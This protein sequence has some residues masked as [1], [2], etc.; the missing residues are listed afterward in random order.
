MRLITFS[1]SNFRSVTRAHRVALANLTVLIGR[2]NEGK[3][4]LLRAL[5]VAMALLQQHAQPGG[6][7]TRTILGSTPS[8][9]VWK[10]DFPV[11]LQARRS[12]TQTILKL[13]F[14][15]S[16]DEIDDFRGDI[17]SNL[18]GILP[19]EIRIGKDEEPHIK[20]VKQGPGAATL[21]S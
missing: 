11:Q 8:P 6:R 7:S 12:S 3:S 21:A 10:R 4:N 18:N 9:Y 2:N 1:V 5:D 16:Q 15:L 19:L 14:E 17:G 20:V 13:E